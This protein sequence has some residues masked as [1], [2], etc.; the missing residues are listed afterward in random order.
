M[1]CGS[2]ATSPLA[3]LVV[4]RA[5]PRCRSVPALVALL[6]HEPMAAEER[7]DFLARATHAFGAAPVPSRDAGRRDP[8]PAP[9]ALPLPGETPLADDAVQRAERLL[10]RQIGPIARLIVRHARAQGTSRE[11]FIAALADAAS[12]CVER[13]RLLE[14]LQRVV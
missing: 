4:R 5:V 11:A 3:A 2:A 6:A 14:E 1:R 9:R 12:D 7:R 13:E 10:L 8:V